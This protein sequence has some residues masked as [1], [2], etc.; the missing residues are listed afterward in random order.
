[1][2]LKLHESLVEVT[3]KLFELNSVT[4]NLLRFLV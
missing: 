4:I 1:M 2:L 3:V